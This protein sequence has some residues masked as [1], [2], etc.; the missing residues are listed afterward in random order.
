LPPDQEAGGWNLA[1]QAGEDVNHPTN[2]PDSGTP[3]RWDEGSGFQAFQASAPDAPLTGEAALVMIRPT[4][5]ELCADGSDG[6]H[7]SGQVTDVAFRGRG[8]E[9]AVDV[10]GSTRLTGVFARTRVARGETVG[11]RLN[12]AGCHMFPADK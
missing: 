2:G 11:L 12:P 4:G 3:V 8:Y 10:D 9:H 7:L 6:H 1:P 5:V